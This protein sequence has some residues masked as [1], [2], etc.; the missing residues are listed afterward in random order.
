MSKKLKLASP[1]Y[2]LDRPSS[3]ND[4]QIRTAMIP[5]SHKLAR[6]EAEWGSVDRL[7]AGISPD[8]LSKFGL[9]RHKLEEAIAAN[10]GDA[11]VKWGAGFM[12]GIKVVE[13]EAAEKGHR[14]S[15]AG[16]THHEVDGGQHVVVAVSADA[17]AAVKAF[18]GA[19]I[20][21]MGELIRMA[22]M[23]EAGRAV[24]TIKKHFPD[25]TVKRAGETKKPVDYDRGGDELPL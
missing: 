16:C 9:V 4:A 10:D 15:L 21:T 14:P 8:T 20:W 22:L 3:D 11:A 18:P 6:I 1:D 17:V 5:I 19:R 12:R 25:A 13:E 23:N 2:L 7:L 24:D